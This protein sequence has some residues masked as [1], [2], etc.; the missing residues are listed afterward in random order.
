[1]RPLDL[2]PAHTPDRAGGVSQGPEL[3]LPR[4]GPLLQGNRR[5]DAVTPDQPPPRPGTAR[6]RVCGA[7]A[8]P[9][10]APATGHFR[11]CVGST[12]VHLFMG[13]RVRPVWG[14]LKSTG[15]W[16]LRVGRSHVRV[17]AQLCEGLRL[18]PRAGAAS[19]VRG[20]LSGG[21][22]VRVTPRTPSKAAVARLSTA[23]GS[24]LP[25]SGRGPGIPPEPGG[26]AGARLGV[27]I[28]S[29]P[30]GRS[31]LRLPSLG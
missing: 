29:Q 21:P 30:D 9:L 7:R 24:P 25:E 14:R 18:R 16:T 19:R 27:H 15:S 4:N 31:L 11:C 28:R 5:S 8:P 20:A 17:C 6:R 23:Q 12:I 2:P 3:L 1:M 22:C 10:T 13:V 26:P